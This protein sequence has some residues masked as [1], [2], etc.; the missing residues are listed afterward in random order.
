MNICL[1]VYK[2]LSNVKKLTLFAMHSNKIN[3]PQS[4]I[5]YINF[6]LDISDMVIVLTT[7]SLH[8]L[9]QDLFSKKVKIISCKNLGRDFGL[10]QQFFNINPIR[11]LRN[12]EGLVLANDSCYC[13]RPLKELYEKNSLKPFWGITDSHEIADHIQS[14]FLSFNSQHVIQEVKK[15]FEINDFINLVEIKDI[16]LYGEI[17]LSQYLIKNDFPFFAEY[18]YDNIS[19]NPKHLNSSIFFWKDLIRLGCPLIKKKMKT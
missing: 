13:I 8:E 19:T 17:G 14:Y 1:N 3:I 12:L 5:T 18:A 11:N 6:L 9:N 2:E 16:V 7:N 15:F 10:W 4:E